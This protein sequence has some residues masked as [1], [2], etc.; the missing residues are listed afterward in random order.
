MWYGH[1]KDGYRNGYG[2]L[3]KP[4]RRVSYGKWVG[5]RKVDK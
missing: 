4:N 1:Y 2:M 3:I 5:D